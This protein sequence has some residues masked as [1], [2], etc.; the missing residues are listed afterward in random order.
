[1]RTWS[2]L[3][4]EVEGR[5]VRFKLFSCLGSGKRPTAC[6]AEGGEDDSKSPSEFSKPSTGSPRYAGSKVE[7]STLVH[8]VCTSKRRHGA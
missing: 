5:T 7:F 8:D 1:M 2:S 3:L 4:K 6:S